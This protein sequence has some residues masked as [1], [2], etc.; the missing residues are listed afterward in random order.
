MR[1]V[2]RL[3]LGVAEPP[4]L[5]LDGGPPPLTIATSPFR[6]I[7]DMFT[8]W[9]APVGIA[10]RR[11][12]VPVGDGDR[13]LGRPRPT[14]RDRSGHETAGCMSERSKPSLFPIAA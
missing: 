11:V 6:G 10:G 12:S 13:L 1:D 9:K 7:T 2:A 5:L 8:V 3:A 4:N 14:G